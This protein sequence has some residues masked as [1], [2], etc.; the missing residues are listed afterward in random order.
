MK[1]PSW[2]TQVRGGGKDGPATGG[3]GDEA[4]AVKAGSWG[5]R[6]KLDVQK[7]ILGL[8]THPI[9]AQASGRI[10]GVKVVSHIYT[11]IYLYLYIHIYSYTH[12]YTYIYG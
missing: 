7:A 9:D 10:R 6:V 4:A 2:T 3:R 5:A 12:V 11:C 8:A 1:Q